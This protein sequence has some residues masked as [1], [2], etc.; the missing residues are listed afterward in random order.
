MNK[1]IQIFIIKQRLL[2]FLTE[3]LREKEDGVE[4][5]T[6]IE[7]AEALHVFFNSTK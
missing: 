7:F 4:H 3:W 1:Q 5:K 2:Q 6:I